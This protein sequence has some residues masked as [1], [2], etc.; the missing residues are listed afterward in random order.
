MLPQLHRLLAQ[1]GAFSKQS[2]RSSSL[3]P[4]GTLDTLYL[5]AA[6]KIPCGCLDHASAM[7]SGFNGSIAAH[8]R[9]EERQLCG[10]LWDNS[11]AEADCL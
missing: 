2:A 4:S 9:G 1:P 10:G 11:T 3:H 7:H 6:L 5:A 8:S